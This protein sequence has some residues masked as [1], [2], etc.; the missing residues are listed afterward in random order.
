MLA[1]GGFDIKYVFGAKVPILTF[2]FSKEE[3]T[4]KGDISFSNLL[5]LHNTKLLESYTSFDARVAPLG[6]MIK[7][8][9]NAVGINSAGNNTFCSIF[10]NFN[11]F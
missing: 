11:W 3:Q 10:Y 2:N 1:E 5:A 9:A 6:L 8:W 4:F 7:R